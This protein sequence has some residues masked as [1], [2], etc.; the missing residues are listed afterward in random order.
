MWRRE[1]LTLLGGAAAAW[2]FAA[3]AQQATM[4]VIGLL[5]SQ[6]PEGYAGPMRGLR[7]GLKDVG[8]EIWPARRVPCTT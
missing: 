2:P 4:P 8:C 3:R 1:F 6:T 7:Q 5:N